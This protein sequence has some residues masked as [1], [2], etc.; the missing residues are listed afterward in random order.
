MPIG[1]VVTKI[2][3]WLFIRRVAGLSGTETV[4]RYYERMRF[5]GKAIKEYE[6]LVS[7]Y[8]KMDILPLPRGPVELFK[9]GKWYAQRCPDKAQ[10]YLTLYLRAEKEDSGTGFGLRH[11]AQAQRLL[12]TILSEQ[13]GVSCK[14]S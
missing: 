12:T 9:L 11:K 8:L 5:M 3:P 1:A 6:H 4:A 13:G 14:L 10:R 7:Q 2:R